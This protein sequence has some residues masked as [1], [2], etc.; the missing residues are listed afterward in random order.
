VSDE[1]FGVAEVVG[2]VD[3]PQFVQHLESPFLS[4]AFGAVERE[5]DHRPASRHLSL[6]EVVLR[7]RW[8]VRVAHP[9]HRRVGRQE[10]RDPVRRGIAVLDANGHGLEALQ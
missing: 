6:G 9:T 1:R 8:Q 3:Q 4:G 10:F 2:D 7:V 5:G